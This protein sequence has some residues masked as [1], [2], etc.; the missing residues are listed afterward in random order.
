[1]EKLIMTKN[2]GLKTRGLNQEH[3]LMSGSEDNSNTLEEKARES[4]SSVMLGSYTDMG[5]CG[6]AIDKSKPISED[7]NNKLDIKLKESQ[8]VFSSITAASYKDLGIYNRS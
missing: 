4:F 6:M 3:K 7:L 8:E 5:L 2:L 1:M